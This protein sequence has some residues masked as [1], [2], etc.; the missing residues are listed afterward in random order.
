MST[1]ILVPSQSQQVR[2]RNWHLYALEDRQL[3][4]QEA[5]VATILENDAGEE[6]D[7]QDDEGATD[8]RDIWEVAHVTEQDFETTEGET[9]DLYDKLMSMTGWTP[10]VPKSWEREWLDLIL[11]DL[12]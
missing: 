11:I 1:T 12:M 2:D 9:E 7:N 10:T 6:Q 4:L 5:N 8:E 3:R